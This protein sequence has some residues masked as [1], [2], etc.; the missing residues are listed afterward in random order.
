MSQQSQTIWFGANSMYA[1]DYDDYY[2][3]AKIHPIY[4]CDLF[5]KGQ[6][7]YGGGGMKTLQ[8]PGNHDL[9]PGFYWRPDFATNYTYNIYLGNKGYMDIGYKMAPRSQFKTPSKFVMLADANVANTTASS[10]FDAIIYSGAFTASGPI[11][12]I[13]CKLKYDQ[14]I[15]MFDPRHSNRANLLFNDCHAASFKLHPT[16]TLWGN[17]VFQPWK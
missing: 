13:S 2:I 6:L 12:E 3:P 17:T 10:L 16:G 11:P 15:K 8:C 4:W 9:T 14:I 7:S 1:N 5:Y